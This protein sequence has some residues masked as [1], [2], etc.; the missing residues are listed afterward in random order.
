MGAKDAV[1]TLEKLG[2]QVNFS[3]RGQVVSQS[4]SSGQRFVK[5]QTINIVLR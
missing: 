2:L 3:G 5:G 4:V 1:Y